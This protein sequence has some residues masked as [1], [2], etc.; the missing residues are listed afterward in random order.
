METKRYC[1][2]LQNSID[3][4]AIGVFDGMHLA[5]QKLFSALSENG[6]ILIIENNLSTLTPKDFRKHFTNR[7]IFY[8]ALSEIKH[9]TGEQFVE[10]LKSDFKNLKKIVV[11]YDFQFG[12]DRSC[13]IVDLKKLFLGE[14]VIIDEVL[15]DNFSVHSRYIREYI[16]NG[17]I[18]LANKLLGHPYKI[19]GVKI[20]GQG[21]GKKEFVATINLITTDFLLPSEGIYVTKTTILDK[22]YNSVTFLGHR[23]STDGTFAIETH[24]L[25]CDIN[26]EDGVVIIDFYK[27]LRNNQKFNSFIELKQ[28]I[29]DD[30]K[31]AKRYFHER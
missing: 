26:F 13:D 6:A 22:T 21:I 24:I 17:E 14:V 30:I 20:K 19:E 25:D 16:K 11:G 28:Q 15:L 12:I 1:L 4:I 3:S 10:K 27:K 31:E 2:D 5:H 8:Y 18:E 29:F 7:E 9:L 23:V